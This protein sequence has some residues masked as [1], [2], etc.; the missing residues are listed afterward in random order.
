MPLYGTV[1]DNNDPLKAGRVRAAIPD[2]FTDPRTGEVIASPWIEAMSGNGDK[3][4]TLDVPQVGAPITVF[5]QGGEMAGVYLLSY[6]KGRLG[7]RNGDSDASGSAQGRDDETASALKAGVPF[8]VPIAATVDSAAAFPTLTLE[9]GTIAGMPGTFNA[10]TYP[11]VR[12]WRSPGGLVVEFDDTPEAQRVH[13]WHPS[14]AYYEISDGG[15]VVRQQAAEWV[16]TLANRTAHV[17]GNEVTAINGNEQRAVGKDKIE[18]IGGQAA[19][20]AQ[21]VALAARGDMLLEAQGN[22]LLKGVTDLRAAAINNFSIEAGGNIGVVSTGNLTEFALSKSTTTVTG[23]TFT[24]PG[25]AA[26]GAQPLAKAPAVGVLLAQLGT[27][28]SGLTAYINAVALESPDTAPAAAA[29]NTVIA[30]VGA[31]LL[32]VAAALPALSVRGS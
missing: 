12:T 14:G 16:R 1:I 21:R 24:T 5:S 31:A 28:L 15:V 10:G 23:A 20:K 27:L 3:A 18:D 17:G 8:S 11:N 13:V 9:R 22:L 6:M 7:R 30:E 32:P 19:L 4:G 25:T 29:L 2:L 26:L